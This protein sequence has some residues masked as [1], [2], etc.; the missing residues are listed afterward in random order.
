MDI[1]SAPK[2]RSLGSPVTPTKPS[3]SEDQ[4]KPNAPNK[5]IR[6]FSEADLH[7]YTPCS[8]RPRLSAYH[9]TAAPEPEISNLSLDAL[10]AEIQQLKIIPSLS[11]EN[12]RRLF[13]K[14]KDFS[15]NCIGWMEIT[16]TLTEKEKKEK[17]QE[18]DNDEEE[19]GVRTYKYEEL[20]DAGTSSMEATSTLASESEEESEESEE[21]V[22]DG[23]DD[24]DEEEEEEER[25]GGY[26]DTED[27]NDLTYDS[28]ASSG[29]WTSSTEDTSSLLSEEV[30]IY[31]SQSASEAELEPMETMHSLSPEDEDMFADDES[32]N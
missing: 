18:D 7:E 13:Y 10:D 32:P 5:L 30:Y 8:K 19:E 22:E 26:Y 20:S 25:G 11:R 9:E 12:E 24:E 29:T 4:P 31:N 23:D 1:D 17:E 3:L 16:S 21:E 28:E 15:G 14:F 6:K 2:T 27:E